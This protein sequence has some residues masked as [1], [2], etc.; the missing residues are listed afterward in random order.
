MPGLFIQRQAEALTRLCNVAVIYVHPDKD[1]PN[2]YEVEF[3]DEKGVRVLRVYYKIPASGD[4]LITGIV[5]IFRYYRAAMKAADSIR[6]FE[7]QLIHAHILTRMGFIAW[8]I[9]RKNKTPFIISEHWSRYFTENG[10]YAGIIRK[11]VTR[12]IV[13][14]AAALIPVSE[15]LKEAIQRHGIH[16]KFV[17]VI[18]NVVDTSLF[19]PRPKETPGKTKIILHV[20]CFDDKSKNITGLLRVLKSLS[21]KRQDFQCLF[22]GEGP[23]FNTIQQYAEG[24]KIIDIFA[25]FKG[26]EEP[27]ILAQEMAAA[28]F[29]VLS[30]CY[31]TF[32]TV[33]VESLS[34]GTPVVATR[35]GIAESII[36]DQNGLLVTPG[37]EASLEAAIDRMLDTCRSYSQ[38]MVRASLPPDFSSASVGNKLVDVYNAVLKKMQTNE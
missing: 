26:R 5:K 29:S 8:R 13:K 7:P 23:D 25:V 14:R 1:C 2:K 37:D 32:A 11:M 12:F 4:N 31:E 18:P 3:A 28:D 30:S 21:S 15:K 33:L 34:C 36:N 24:L 10:S 22:V 9:S 27:E 17:T 20:S 38:D 6:Q 35:T 16:N 19:I